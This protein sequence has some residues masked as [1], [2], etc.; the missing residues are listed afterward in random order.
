M[1]TFVRD[2]YHKGIPLRH[3]AFTLG[4]LPLQIHWHAVPN[5]SFG[6]ACP[7]GS[8]T[9]PELETR[10]VYLQYLRNCIVCKKYI[11]LQCVYIQYIPSNSFA[12]SYHN[13]EA[14]SLFLSSKGK[15]NSHKGRLL[16]WWKNF[17]EF[18]NCFSY[19]SSIFCRILIF[20][21]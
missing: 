4:H 19:F 7:E 13:L 12:T 3:S 17:S 15:V 10:P 6:G 20:Y 8:Y 16:P 5:V 1:L 18:L 14:I 21:S 11:S 9:S 2:R